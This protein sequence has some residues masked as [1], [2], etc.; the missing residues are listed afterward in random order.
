MKNSGHLSPQIFVRGIMPRSGTNFMADALACHARISRFPGDFWEFVPFR[1]QNELDAYLSRINN[2]NHAPGFKPSEFLPYFG[3]AWMQYLTGSS[4]GNKVALFKEPSVDHLEAMFQMFPRAK[5]VLMVRDG[6][7]LIESLLNAG[8]GLP[9]RLLRNPHHWRRFLPDED[10][11]ILC[12]QLGRAA[13]RLESFL[14]SQSAEKFMDQVKLVRF[15]DLFA[16]S[17]SVLKDVLA[18]CD[19]PSGEFDWEAFRKMPVRG[20]SFL[21]DADG[22]MNF[23]VGVTRSPEFTPV[24]RWASWSS[25]RKLYYAGT[26][27]KRFRSF[28]YTV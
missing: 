3:D 8:F 4:G 1:F 15:E 13:G 21:R 23:G 19:L 14:Q 9:P 24:G 6:R 28:G 2:P 26:V 10:F 16:S 11:R 18:W 5:V 17:E 27:G 7:D 22:S 12:R 20:S 25:R